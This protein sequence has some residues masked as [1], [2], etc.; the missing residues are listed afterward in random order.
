MMG[1]CEI[2]SPTCCEQELIERKKDFLGGLKDTR[3]ERSLDY[4]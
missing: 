2:G 3:G 4:G 1:A